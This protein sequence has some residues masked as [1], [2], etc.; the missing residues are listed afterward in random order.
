MNLP[1]R[2]D[3]NV[4]GSLDEQTESEHFFGK[5][6]Q[7]AELLFREDCG[8][9]CEDLMWMG[10]KAF[11]LYVTAAIRYLV[12]AGEHADDYDVQG[13]V[14]AVSDR[15]KN[16]GNELCRDVFS[17][18]RGCLLHIL[19]HW[20]D[21]DINETIYTELRAETQELLRQVEAALNEPPR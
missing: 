14:S 20:G 13:F 5:D 15:L 2:K 3:I 4:Y 19:S 9:Y 8:S 1:T 10:I 17:D 6:L 18:I 11:Q 12:S 21:Y 7:A 16:E